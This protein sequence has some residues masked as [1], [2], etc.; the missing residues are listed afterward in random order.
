MTNNIELELRAEIVP[1]RFG[2]LLDQLKKAYRLISQT[3]RLSAMFIGSINNSNYDMRVRIDSEKKVELVVK[4]GDFHSHNR[5]EISQQIEASQFLGLVKIL[6]LLELKSK[7]TERENWLF[8]V[9]NE[10]Y[11]SL[12]R[13]GNIAY[14]EI[15]KMSN[16]NTI[17]ENQKE[18]L[19]L[20][21]NLDL[22][23]IENEKEFNELC[24]RLTKYSDWEFKGET[25]DYQK[26]EN[27]LKTY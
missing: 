5:T 23:L 13:A 10:V 20:I 8:D 27:L 17:E 18:L 15:E 4:R 2:I 16:A 6:S 19:R 14:V 12:V 22:K 24:E 1:E 7:I 21:K 11:L 26:L 25:N 3:K 9:G